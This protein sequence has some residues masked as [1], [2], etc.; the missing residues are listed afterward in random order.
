MILTADALT[1]FARD[2]IAASGSLRPEAEEVALHLVEANLKGHDSHGVGMIPTYVRNV[3][4]GYLYPNRHATRV[5]ETGAV[6]VFDGGMGYGQVIAREAMDWGIAKAKAAGLA[7][8]ALRNTHHVARVGTYGEQ[9]IASGLIS[10]HFVN[11]LIAPGRVAPFGGRV[12]RYGT[13]P[14]CIAVPGTDKVPPV[15][16]DFATSRVAAGK[17]RVAMNEGKKMP[18]GMLIDA[19][20]NDANDPKVFYRENG[21]MLPFGEHKGSGLAL[22]CQ[23]LAGALTGGGVMQGDLPNHGVKNGM[24]AIL[25]DPA[26]F[27]D[28]AAMRQDMET[29]IAWVKSAPPRPGTDAVMV[30]GDP[31][32]KAREK[33]LKDGIPID[34]N[35]WRE[36]VEAAHNAGVE[37]PADDRPA[38]AA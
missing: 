15:V 11:V 1:V 37:V 6:A 3:A 9:A 17:L 34:A 19:D 36:L 28:L 21:A 20:G 30:A 22:A 24:F 27:G 38:P 29:L 7:A 18:P 5:S 13:D 12:G 31:E 33:R 16:L 25:I 26:Q 32:R 10:I 23:L 4:A 35:T 14:V 8:F 2:I